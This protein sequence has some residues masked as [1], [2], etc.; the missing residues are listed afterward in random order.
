ML[1]GLLPA[2]IS[3]A[4]DLTPIFNSTITGGDEV[5]KAD[6]NLYSAIKR[7]EVSTEGN[8]TTIH[9]GIGDLFLLG[10]ELSGSADLRVDGSVTPK[11]FT[12]SSDA[13]YDQFVF[14]IRLFLGCN[15][16]K[17]LQFGCKNIKLPNGIT[18]ELKSDDTVLT[19]PIIYATEDFKNK[20]SSAG[21]FKFDI[22]SG[23]DQIL[24]IFRSEQP[25]VIRKTGTFGTDDYLK[26]TINDDL[27]GST[28]GNLQEFSSLI[29]GFKK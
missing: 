12:F 22:T 2:G 3:N 21:L 29:L 15:G 26:I 24:A 11:V 28:G 17:Y 5:H 1:A 4:I 14:E 9:G 8:A 27:T 16:I 25:F 23:A 18:V 19:F 13:T 20:F 7:L 6:V 10:A